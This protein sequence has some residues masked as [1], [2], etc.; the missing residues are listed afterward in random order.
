MEAFLPEVRQ[1]TVSVNGKA[2]EVNFSAVVISLGDIDSVRQRFSGEVM[3]ILRWSSSDPNFST[4][5]F[6]RLAVVNSHNETVTLKKFYSENNNYTSVYEI[7][8]EYSTSMS[9]TYFPFD[10]QHLPIEFAISPVFVNTVVGKAE[11]GILKDSISIDLEWNVEKIALLESSP[12]SSHQSKLLDCSN[13]I[14]LTSLV[15]RKGSYYFWNL[16][17]L[18]FYLGE[19]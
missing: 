12:L 16:F 6:I 3:V 19:Y 13:I 17:S 15:S 14:T 2:L 7:A 9:F 11:M 4:P 1:R 18:R 8:A 5:D 10:W